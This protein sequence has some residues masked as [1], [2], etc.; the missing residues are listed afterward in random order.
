MSSHANVY[1]KRILSIDVNLLCTSL[2]TYY[3]HNVLYLLYKTPKCF[4]NYILAIFQ[5]LL[6]WSTCTAKMAN[7]H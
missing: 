4:G 5:D 3:L 2:S 7:C 6:L 1:G